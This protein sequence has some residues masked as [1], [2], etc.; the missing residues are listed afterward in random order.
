MNHKINLKIILKARNKI[1]YNKIGRENKE[2]EGRKREENV[3]VH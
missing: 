3:T 2:K 1:D